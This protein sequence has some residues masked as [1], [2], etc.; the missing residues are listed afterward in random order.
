MQVSRNPIYGAQ[1]SM[2][3]RIQSSPHVPGIDPRP[4]RSAVVRIKSAGRQALDYAGFGMG[5]FA[6]ACD[7]CYL[8]YSWIEGVRI[9]SFPSEDVSVAGLWMGFYYCYWLLPRSVPVVLGMAIDLE[10][11]V[12][13][14]LDKVWIAII[15]LTFCAL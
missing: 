2:A 8:H 3:K 4:G 13:M 6:Y 10:L 12:V 14:L 9:S 7:R 1:R 15:H 11:E 5:L